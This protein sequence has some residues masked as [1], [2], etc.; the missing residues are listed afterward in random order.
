MSIIASVLSII[1]TGVGGTALYR[2]SK[3]SSNQEIK[4]NKNKQVSGNHNKIK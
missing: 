1:A 2:V 3:I 4:G